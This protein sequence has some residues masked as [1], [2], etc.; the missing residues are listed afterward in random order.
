MNKKKDP[1]YA[2][3]SGA[4]AKHTIFKTLYHIRKGKNN[5]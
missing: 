4:R 5:E 2:G 1:G 3:G